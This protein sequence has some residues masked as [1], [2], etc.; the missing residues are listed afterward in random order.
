MLGRK[1]FEAGKVCTPGA[2]SNCHHKSKNI[3][4]G[5]QNT[6]IQRMQKSDPNIEPGLLLQ[7]IVLHVA[8]G[9]ENR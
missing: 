2:T 1:N 4:G 9:K 3:Y 5:Q 6:V 7:F 8:G